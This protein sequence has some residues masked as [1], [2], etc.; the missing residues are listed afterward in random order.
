MC[1]TLIEHFR[2]IVVDDYDVKV[3]ERVAHLTCPDVMESFCYVGGKC[4]KM[5][6][7]S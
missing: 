2:L 7:Y 6:K 4:R 1:S 5:I 3:I